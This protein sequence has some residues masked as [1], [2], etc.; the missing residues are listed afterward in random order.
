M[1]MKSWK[2]EKQEKHSGKGRLWEKAAMEQKKY[3][4]TKISDEILKQFKKL[5]KQI[6]LK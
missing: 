1:T 4:I 6:P 5:T 3:V 2:E